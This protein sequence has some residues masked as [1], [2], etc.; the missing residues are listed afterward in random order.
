QTGPRR[1]PRS[2]RGIPARGDGALTRTRRAGPE[3]TRA[4]R[5]L[6][7]IRSFVR[8]V[9]A[10]FASYPDA[11]NGWVRHP[12]RPAHRIDVRPTTCS[13]LPRPAGMLV[14]ATRPTLGARSVP[15]R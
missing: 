2:D 15:S 10:W 4:E 13:D 7:S 3:L 8:V 1:C 5:S 6:A 14:T 9:P 11:P 12:C